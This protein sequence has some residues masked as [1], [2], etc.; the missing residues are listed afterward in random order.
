LVGVVSQSPA[1]NPRNSLSLTLPLKACMGMRTV[2]GSYLNPNQQRRLVV[3]CQYVDKLLSELESS[4]VESSS[5]AAF[6]RY[7]PDITLAQRRTIE[8]YI[9]RI[10]T[11]LVRVLDSQGI[12]RPEPRIPTSRQLHVNLTF[13]DIA[14]EELKPKYMRGYGEVH[15]SAATELNGLVGE[16]QDI[17]AQFDRY[18]SLGVGDDLQQRL[19]ALEQVGD[20]VQLLRTLE[21]I[22]TRHGFVEFRSSLSMLLDRLEDTTFEI[23]IFGRVSSGKS[24]LLNAILESEVLPVGVTPITAVPTR[25]VY[26]EPASVKVWFATRPVE[27]VE[28]SRLPEFVAEHENPGNHKNVTRIV[29]QLPAQHLQGGIAFVDTPGLGSLATSG[30]AETLAYL[31][32]CDLG[33]VLVDAGSTLTADDLKTVQS[34]YQA[35]IP[36]NVLLSKADLLTPQDRARVVSYVRDHVAAELNLHLSVHPVSV[37]G[38]SR[39]LLTEWFET[40]IRPLYAQREELR[41]HSIRR[42]VGT[43]RQS[44]AAALRMRLRRVEHVSSELSDQLRAVENR[45]RQATAELEGARNISKRAVDE[46]GWASG[47]ALKSAAAELVAAWSDG[48]PAASPAEETIKAAI[49]KIVQERAETIQQHLQELSRDLYEAVKSAGEA[50]EQPHSLTEEEFASA[51]REMPMLDLGQLPVRA[52]RPAVSMLLGQS[53]AAARVASQLRRQIGAPLEQTL[54][55]YRLVLNEWLDATLQ[56]ISSRFQAYAD[57]YRAQIG[58]LLNDEQLTSQQERDIQRNLEE[59]ET[60]S[61]APA[62]SLRRA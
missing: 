50:L 35:G 57:G 26:G 22:I 41:R 33:V 37:I 13:I 27:R 49:G 17:I 43:L 12:E 62:Q 21:E 61:P 31:P 48:Q 3:T 60:E 59:L 5:K 38:N 36:A 29:V 30:A 52:H 24:S 56:N 2:A 34:L 58:R 39:A 7:V 55:A 20:E 44:V 53:L 6:P 18:V 4:L 51:V 14:V 42:K 46:I 25:I 54:R 40:E 15:S 11:Q 8:D 28:L 16:L 32:R 23:A 47:D 19:R 1:P 9:A 45:L 10:R